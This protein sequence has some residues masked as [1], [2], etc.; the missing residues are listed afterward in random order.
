M[1]PIYYFTGLFFSG[2]IISYSIST[3]AVIIIAV[4]IINFV[5]L[6]VNLI[7]NRELSGKCIAIT[8][9][10]M[11]MLS[12]S[13]NSTIPD[14]IDLNGKEIVFDGYVRG[15][16]QYNRNS[17]HYSVTVERYYLEDRLVVKKFTLNYSVQKSYGE[18]IR[19]DL[20]RGKCRVYINNGKTFCIAKGD[21][22]PFVVERKGF[23]FLNSIDEYKRQI[24]RFIFERYS[25]RVADILL[26][27]AC[28]NSSDMQYETRSVFSKT[29]TAHILAISG[30][31]IG[32]ISVIFY[33][34]FRILFLPLTLIRPFSLKKAATVPLIFTIICISIYFGD[35]ASVLRSSVMIIIYLISILIERDR[36]LIASLCVSFVLI[37]SFD[38]NSIKDVG[39]QLS[40]LSVFGIILFLSL[41]GESDL[42]EEESLIKVVLKPI[43]ILFLSS[44][45]ASL[46]T[47]PVVAYHFGVISL[48]GFLANIIVVPFVG[49]VSLPLILAGAV[50]YGFSPSISEFFFNGA[51]VSLGNLYDINLFF[52]SIPFSSVRIFKP[53]IV[54]ILL[55][56]MPLFSIVLRKRI[57]FFKIVILLESLILIITSLVIDRIFIDR[58]KPEMIVRKGV[59]VM[60]DRDAKGHLIVMRDANNRD[61]RRAVDILREKRLIKVGY[62]NLGLFDDLYIRDHLFTVEDSNMVKKSNSD[63][64]L[65]KFMNRYIYVFYDTLTCPPKSATFVISRRSSKEAI[66]KLYECNIDSDKLI[67]SSNIKNANLISVLKDIYGESASKILVCKD[68][69]CEISIDEK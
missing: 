15:S 18:P 40:F 19:G 42:N 65:I 1:A 69:D 25:G 21:N 52:S 24:S 30:T 34:V 58:L 37:V 50:T 62:T 68:E 9:L 45:S 6:S 5:L 60:I 63:D 3:S 61:I 46:F 41:R 48:I 10:L 33:F 7:K 4:L 56:Y 13:L 38:P 28:G 59:I 2:V 31:H 67:I 29:G 39:F 23:S 57:P 55:F 16:P 20:I 53:H 14:R 64:A 12:V 47:L 17:I 66:E 22:P 27:L 54:E 26:A 44:L 8:G 35:S 51:F 49:M 36:N 43:L 32:L 11:G